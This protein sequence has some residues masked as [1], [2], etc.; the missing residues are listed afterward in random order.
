MARFFK[1]LAAI[2]LV[3][4]LTF[5]LWAWWQRRNV[6]AP[7]AA[8]IVA[9]LRTEPES[10]NRLVSASAAVD[11]I[12]NL[13]HAPLIKVDRQTG[14]P[15]PWLAERWDT[16]SP[17]SYRLH[18]HRSARFSD[19]TPFTA[20]DVAFTFRAA[21]D[22]RVNSALGNGLRVAGMPLTVTVED[23]NTV[24]IDFPAEYGPGLAILDALPMLPRHKL[25]EALAAGRFAEAWGASAP[26]DTVAGLGPFVVREV[27]AGES[28]TFARNPQYFRRDQL[29]SDDLADLLVVRVVPDQSAEMVQLESGAADLVTSGLRAE[30]MASFR[31]LLQQGRVTLYDVGVAIDPNALWF[32]LKPGAPQSLERPWLQRTELR[33]AISRGVSRQRIIDTVFLGAAEPVL[34]PVTP[35]HGAWH[36]A[37]VTP[38]A[39]DAAEAGRLLSALGLVDRN[40]DGIREDRRGRPARIALLTQRGHTIRERMAAIIQEDLR[41]IGLAVDIVAL[42]TGALIARIGSGDYDAVLFGLQASS[43]DP[44]LNLDFWLPSGTFHLWNPAQPAPATGWEAEIAALMDR[45]AHSADQ[46]DRHRAFHDVQRIFAREL[47][48][49]YF[50]APRVVIATSARLTGVKPAV[51]LPHV[52][53]MPEALGTKR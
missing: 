27:R 22:E 9:T 12:T 6:Q 38:P 17:T 5:G 49:I 35:G 32:N 42:E 26:I 34:T 25:E 8:P 11:V 45:V 48:A 37:D 44:S 13:I 20:A 31:S 51:P 29:P 21:Y 46:E 47:P 28:M 14:E 19:G 4:I 30:D 53:W 39:H 52:L 24:R 10:F 2:A 15:M 7:D 41:R 50:A 40:G 16:L 3:A 18:L 23:N 1:L 43:P 36:A 33:Q